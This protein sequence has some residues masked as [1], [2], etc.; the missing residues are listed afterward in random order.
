MK[1]LHART[2]EGISWNAR[3]PDRQV[4]ET[5]AEVR[6]QVTDASSHHHVHAITTGERIGV[7]L[8]FVAVV[9]G[10]GYAANRLRRAASVERADR[11]LAAEIDR[12]ATSEE[13]LVRCTRDALPKVGPL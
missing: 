6:I 2:E 12:A 4:S 13:P 7:G 11:I 1:L 9:A 10:L 5:N 8:V 3:Y